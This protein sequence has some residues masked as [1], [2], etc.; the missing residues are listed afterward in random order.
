MD[1]LHEQLRLYYKGYLMSSEIDCHV[2]GFPI[3]SNACPGCAI[4][5][6]LEQQMFESKLRPLV[7]GMI[8]IGAV[9]AYADMV[10]D[11]TGLKPPWTPNG[12]ALKQDE[13]R[14][15]ARRAIMAILSTS[16]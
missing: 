7:N 15:I 14:A 8:E 16:C 13:A 9:L 6:D 2:C 5:L 10:Y 1:R 12:N 3:G 11:G 4:A